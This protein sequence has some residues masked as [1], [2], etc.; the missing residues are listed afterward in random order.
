MS[1]EFTIDQTVVEYEGG[2]RVF[3]VV[4]VS[5]VS[6]YNNMMVFGIAKE[7]SL[8]TNAHFCIWEHFISECKSVNTFNPNM[9]FI[10]KNDHYGTSV[11]VGKYFGGGCPKAWRDA[12]G[13]ASFGSSVFVLETCWYPTTVELLARVDR[14]INRMV[15]KWWRWRIVSL[16]VGDLVWWCFNASRRYL[17]PRAVETFTRLG[18]ARAINYCIG[19]LIFV[20]SNM[21]KVDRDKWVEYKTGLEM[22][23][24]VLYNDS[25]F[26]RVHLVIRVWMSVWHVENFYAPHVA[27]ECLPCPDGLYLVWQIH[28]KRPE[29]PLF[30]DRSWGDVAHTAVMVLVVDRFWSCY[31]P[32]SLLRVTNRKTWGFDTWLI[33]ACEK[34]RTR[35][36][37]CFDDS[38]HFLEFT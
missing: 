38:N 25:Y 27:G 3:D 26:Y 22:N 24:T 11:D 14:T 7:W 5:S 29:Q 10:D 6:V 23:E 32:V 17:L 2:F 28:I 31:R 8:D 30:I 16:L 20:T 13:D 19:S 4:N 37:D 33:Q 9:A 15:C 21:R 34:R 35:W 12:I 36:Y 18:F 1:K